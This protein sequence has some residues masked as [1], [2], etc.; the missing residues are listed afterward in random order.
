[1]K[2][3][4]V[5]GVMLLCSATGYAQQLVT[6]TND[7]PIKL[8]DV[9][10]EYEATHNMNRVVNEV[11]GKVIE[12]EKYHFDRWRW[13]WEQH[14]DDNGYLVSP[15][16]TFEEWFKISGRAQHKTTASQADWKFRGPTSSPGGYNGVGRI[17]CIEFHPTDTNTY[18]VGA[19]GGGIWK[20]TNDGM[21]WTSLSDNL[22]R[23]DVSDIDVNP[24]N[25]N[26]MYLCTGDR[27]G[28]SASYNNNNS[29]G[30]LK[31][32]D[33][34]Q[35]WNTTGITWTT[36]QGRTTN[37][38][39]I[40]PADTN[41]LTLATSVGIYKSF[42]GGTTWTSTLSGNYSQV[43]YKP[44]DTTTLYAARNSDT[45][46]I[47]RSVNGG[48]TW[49][50]TSNFNNARR[51]ALAV[52]PANT[53]LVRAMVCNS[54]NGLM[55][56][57]ESTNSGASFTLKY[58]PTGSN[59][60]TKKGD[61]IVG[62]LNG[63]G[64]GNQ[65]WYDLA[66]AIHPT[67]TDI[68]YAGGVNTYG[69]SNG[70]TSWTLATQWYAGKPGI[71]TV[72]A[73][74]HYYAYHPL[75]GE[76]FECNDGGLYKTANPSSTLWMDLTNGMGITQFYRNA[77]T[78][79]ANY[80]LG[81]SQDNGSKGLDAGVWYELTG[82]DGMECQADPLDSNVYYTAIQNGEI[83]RTTNGGSSYVDIDNNIPGQP[84][85][86]WITPYIISPNNNMHLI[87][88]YK[89]IYFSPDRGDNWM[90]IQ[91]SEVD[92]ENCTRLAM[93]GGT[94][95]TIYAI[96]PDTA[97]VFYADNF[98][99]GSNATFDT[100]KVPYGENISDIRPHPVDS[101]RFYLSFSG[102]GATRVAEYNKGVWSQ[103][104][105]G[106]PSVPV[107]CLD[108]DTAL[109]VLYAGTDL[110]VYYMDSSTAGAWDQFRKNMPPV[111]VLD[112]GINYTTKEI[113]AATY[114]RGMWSSVKQGSVVVTPPID[115]GDTTNSVVIIPYAE[116]V[117][118]IAPNPAKDG[119]KIILG[120]APQSSNA[121]TV[122]VLDYTGKT[123]ISMPASFNGGK[124]DVNASG[125]P[126]GVYIVELR[127]AAAVL[128][129]KR[130][131]I[132]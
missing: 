27:D 82:G 17:N 115:T 25:P 114:G 93:T 41:S 59:C 92:N 109:N 119:F 61:L 102:Y 79:V 76:F 71:V 111:E 97:V 18:W 47:Y 72:H 52:S 1:M 75:T 69:S 60:N 87:A 34:G 101:G 117:F 96:F 58:A 16:A 21:N 6:D 94:T 89:H 123:V 74:K 40:N 78:N 49:T 100:I 80:V 10:A 86:A 64:C 15:A 66:I 44:G 13:Y 85:G 113:W 65:G 32:L 130:V 4:Y 20:T 14:L 36:S 124:A 105:T 110:G 23:L 112:L 31:S 3:L 126:A 132:Q 131:V 43:I 104:N 121:I 37:W 28:G 8:S 88:G 107:R 120:S 50:V 95:P 45:R 108:Y 129:R 42:N 70:G 5:L 33:G 67:N 99:A 68:M 57:Y 9:V 48:M 24:L 91:G 19:S 11:N 125:L 46:Q 2:R 12:G 90:S 103:L 98:V 22:P 51:I 54:G 7:K 39:L 29:V 30:V 106:L 55:G 53:S 63:N 26:T 73:D 116:D 122:N 81:G 38:L 77:V 84:A 118:N 83:R 127:D 56:I 62:D 35:T 128:G